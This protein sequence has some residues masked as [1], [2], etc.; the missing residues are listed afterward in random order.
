[1]LR[2]LYTD[3]RSTLLNKGI[4]ILM[5]IFAAYIIGYVL[6]LNAI[7]AFLGTGSVLSADEVLM[8]YNESSIFVVTAATLI[9]Y[10]GEFTNG[11]IRNKLCSGAK[12]KEIVIAALINSAF[13]SVLM[14][15][16]CQLLEIILAIIFSSGLSSMTLSEAA[17]SLLETTL[18][19][20]A[21]AVFSASI[22]MIMGGSYASYIVG[23]GV[24][25]AFKIF[26]IVV[27]RALYPDY[28]PVT[29]TGIKLA[30]YRFYDR[31]V[32][33]SRCTGMPRWD[34]QSLL[35]GCAGLIIISVVMGLIVF[36]KKELK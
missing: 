10:V 11:S 9:V 30:V 23:L 26:G 7:I 19:S 29:I 36:D 34:I 6:L 24:A 4:K 28:G 21:I 16:F 20:V 17:F 8:V 13:I 2:M 5:L 32:P 18:S 15:V 27:M 12:R 22:I 35:M 31:F 14:S 25:F 1:M 33:Y 3:F